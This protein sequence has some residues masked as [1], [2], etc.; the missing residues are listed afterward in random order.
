[1]RILI[2]QSNE[3]LGNLWKRHL[4]RLGAEVTLVSTGVR[5]CNIIQSN[6]FDVIV[7]DLILSDGCALTVADFANFRQPGANVV[8]VTDT[9]FFSDGSIFNHS[10][11]ARAFV[12]STT[13]PGDLAVI[14]H[15]YGATSRARVAH[16][17]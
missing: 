3:N 11:N 12:K 1:M 14:V 16:H 7:L 5:A 6:E 10:A 15:H 9:T 4:G 2:V 13:A 8:F 17:S